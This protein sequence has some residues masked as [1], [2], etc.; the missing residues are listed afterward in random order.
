MLTAAAGLETLRTIKGKCKISG[1]RC[2][3]EE[4]CAVLGYYEASSGNFL[5]TFR[6]NLS[7]PSSR[8]KNPKITTTRCVITHK[9][10]VLNKKKNI[11]SPIVTQPLNLLD[12]FP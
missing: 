5:Q 8:I 10:V 9:D 6:D 7:A 1:F 11:Y 12:V 2:E 4:S 3:A